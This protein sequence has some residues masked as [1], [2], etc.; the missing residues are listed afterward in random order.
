LPSGSPF[1]EYLKR[2]V[3]ALPLKVRVFTTSPVSR[4]STVTS[5]VAASDSLKLMTAP[6]LGHPSDFLL[7]KVAGVTLKELILGAVVSP[8]GGGGGVPPCTMTL[9]AIP[10]PPLFPCCSQ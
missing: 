4:R 6:L 10:T 7:Q 1:P 9:P 3:P 2:F 8:E 5:T